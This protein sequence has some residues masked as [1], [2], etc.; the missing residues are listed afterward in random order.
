M[1]FVLDT[2]RYNSRQDVR[3]IKRFARDVV[4]RM[5]FRHG[6]FRVGVVD[7]GTIARTSL[8]LAEGDNKRTVKSVLGSIRYV[9]VWSIFL[10]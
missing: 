1:V 9:C 2:S 7:F 8:T 4:K 5:A 10:S 3:H 6:N